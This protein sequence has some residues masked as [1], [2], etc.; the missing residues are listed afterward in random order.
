MV[1]R[2]R[3]YHNGSY[4]LTITS[5]ENTVHYINSPAQLDDS[6]DY[7]CRACNRYGCGRSSSTWTVRVTGLLTL[8]VAYV[9][10]AV[11]HTCVIICMN[12]SV[13]VFGV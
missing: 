8:M 4:I 7:Y 9:G 3:W 11:V 5:T 12:I 6:G 1:E 2:Y 13:H 10:D